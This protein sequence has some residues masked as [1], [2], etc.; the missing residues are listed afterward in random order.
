MICCSL[1]TFPCLST[2][3][4]S[5]MSRSFRFVLR[6]SSQYS[7]PEPASLLPWRIPHNLRSLSNGRFWPRVVALYLSF[8]LR[9]K[10]QQDLWKVYVFYRSLSSISFADQFLFSG[11]SLSLE[12]SSITLLH[13]SQHF[14]SQRSLG[15][16]NSD[17]INLDVL[18]WTSYIALPS[19]QADFP[20]LY[21]MVTQTRT[22]F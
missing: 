8:Q 15:V 3:S 22:L 20:C 12:S 18:M 21:Y 17:L 16:S 2:I 19:P 5:K 7:Y 4:S 11:V 14:Y 13:L 1:E 9:S 10:H 6:L